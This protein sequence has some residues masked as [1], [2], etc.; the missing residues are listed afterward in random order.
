MPN[1][2]ASSRQIR[3]PISI[4]E[5]IDKI[6]IL[7]IKAARMTD[8]AKLRNVA[9]ELMLLDQTK[10]GAGLDTPEMAPYAR[11]LKALNTTLWEI[12]NALRELEAR[13]DFGSRFVELARKVY[14][15][16]DERARVKQ[17]INIEF[18]SQLVEEKSYNNS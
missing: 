3:V 16:N 6:T 12:E 17:R 5:L 8:S 14:Q 10:V 1:S 13:Q 15:T 9:T 4:G 11:E 7:E 2:N 18:G